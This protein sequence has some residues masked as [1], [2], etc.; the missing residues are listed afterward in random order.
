MTMGKRI[1]S[2][3]L[4]MALA[5]G[6]CACG[7]KAPTWQEQ[8]DLGVRYLSDGNYEEAILAF[9]AAIDIDSKRPEAYVG[10]AD[11]YEQSG[12]PEQAI[13]IL[14]SAI[15]LLGEL[16]ELLEIL[17][18]LEGNV[19][20]QEDET[21]VHAENDD[22]TQGVPIPVQVEG[23]L[24]LSNIMCIFSR[25]SHV[26]DMN[27]DAVAGLEF[28]VTVNGPETVHGLLIASWFSP[29]VSQQEIDENISWLVSGWKED[30]YS[31]D[32]N[33]PFTITLA[34]PVDSDELGQRQ[35]TVL[36]G[37]DEQ[38]NVVGYTLVTVDI[39]N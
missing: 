21:P 29:G 14:R 34:R 8:Y 9:T 37:L 16:P 23:G 30:G 39:P 24:E 38:V 2:L 19:S 15:D 13:D 3:V 7:S 1:F 25:D 33:P 11:S 18:S 10:L 26:V 4:M 31:P 20:T 12:Q 27:E 17:E 35:A 22:S 28:E 32:Q 6:V 36:V 5:L